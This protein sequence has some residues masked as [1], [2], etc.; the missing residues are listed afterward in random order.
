MQ[1]IHS[2][3][4]PPTADLFDNNPIN[5]HHPSSIGP[6]VIVLL[7]A[8]PRWRVSKEVIT[9]KSIRL[10]LCH[11][12]LVCT[13]VEWRVQELALPHTPQSHTLFSSHKHLTHTPHSHTSLTHTHH[14]H[15]HSL[16]GDVV[17]HTSCSSFYCFAARHNKTTST[18]TA[19]RVRPVSFGL[20]QPSAAILLWCGGAPVHLLTSFVAPLNLHY[21]ACTG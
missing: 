1:S 18:T 12:I 4:Q 7:R 8:L 6:D 14:T 19:L 5:K 11:Q 10:K 20:L 21:K 17:T 2:L 9:D 16:P 15:T 3:S 13:C